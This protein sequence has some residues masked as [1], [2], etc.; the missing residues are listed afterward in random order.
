MSKLMLS[1]EV[2]DFK[3]GLFILTDESGNAVRRYEDDPEQ[4]FIVLKD[5][6]FREITLLTST[7][8]QLKTRQALYA[9]PS[10]CA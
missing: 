3:E 10:R 5:V 7:R 1:P 2:S 4:G 9:G 6:Q 8:L